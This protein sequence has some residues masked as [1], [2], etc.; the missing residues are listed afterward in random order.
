MSSASN[1]GLF[2]QPAGSEWSLVLNARQHSMAVAAA[3][4]A[5]TARRVRIIALG[6]AILTLLWIGVDVVAFDKALWLPLAFGRIVAAMAFAAVAVHESDRRSD[7]SA[8]YWLAALFAVPAC[9][10]I[11]STAILAALPTASM[12][13]LG[14][15]AYVHLPFIVMVGLAIFPL[16]ARENALLGIPLLC[17]FLLTPPLFYW[18]DGSLSSFALGS[19]A[20]AWP[21]MLVTGVAAIAGTSQ[22]QLLIAATEQSARDKLTGL[23]ARR[24]GEEI[25]EFQFDGAERSGAPLSAVFID[26]DLFKSV[27]DQYGH[28]AG[29][30][31]LQTA[32]QH[33]LG[34]LRRQ[35]VLIRWGGE[36]FLAL[37]PNTD[38]DEA[39]STI[40]RIAKAGLGF[41]PD[42]HVQTASLG[43]AERICDE[44]GDWRQ[45]IEI[46]DGRM[47][48]AKT[49]GRNQVV[50]PHDVAH[51]FIARDQAEAPERPRA[52]RAA[53]A[54]VA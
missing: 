18:L 32:A 50:C 38:A 48:A 49:A 21:L 30:R 23:Y 20:T 43:L 53:Y 9:F 29:D 41:R 31:V 19:S 25:F 15:A 44:V 26:L 2:E 16:T 14:A 33:L 39:L 5:L 52:G 13:L 27:N 1:G 4:S 17:V 12:P 42:G 35:D 6:F 22:L 10:F 40:K 28:D 24:L 47:Y 34:A 37:M 54:Q 3:R 51:P 45:M 36:E 8:F 7:R 46:A 11:Y